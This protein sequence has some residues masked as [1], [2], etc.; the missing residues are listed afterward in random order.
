MA[1]YGSVDRKPVSLAE[2][3][4]ARVAADGLARHPHLLELRDGGGLHIGRDLADAVHLL[5]NVHGRHP[6][7]IELALRQADPARGDWLVR[8]ASQLEQERLFLVRLTAAVGP[9]PSTPG[10]SETE[11]SLQAQRH[12][13]ETLALSERRGCALGAAIA[14]VGDWQAVRWV[15]NRAAARAGMDTPKMV[16]PDESSIHVAISAAADGPAAERALAFGAEQLLLQHRALFD[17]LEARAEARG[18]F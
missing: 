7:L 1:T 12:A 8:A 11:A 4:V 18:D 10:A 15:L 14:L 3:Q 13:L 9:M 5:C 16:I 2:A 6:G 17:L